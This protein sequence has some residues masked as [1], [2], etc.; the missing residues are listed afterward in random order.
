M[1][2]HTGKENAPPE[3]SLGQKALP[4]GADCS[5]LITERDLP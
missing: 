1:C 3:F 2:S 5:L 4:G